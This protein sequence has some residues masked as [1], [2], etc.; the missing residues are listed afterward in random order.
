MLTL[1]CIR[2]VPESNYGPEAEYAARD[3]RRFPQF[4]RANAKTVP[5]TGH[6]RFLPHLFQFNIPDHP[7]FDAM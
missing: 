7:S 3:S 6:D 4:I 5:E 1:L 2:E